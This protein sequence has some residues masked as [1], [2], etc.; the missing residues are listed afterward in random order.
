LKALLD[1]D[2]TRWLTVK[3]K[4]DL[5]AVLSIL[6]RRLFWDYQPTESPQSDKA[7]KSDDAAILVYLWDD[8]V[9]FILQQPKLKA[10]KK[11]AANVIRKALHH[12]WIRKVSLS[13]CDWWTTYKTVIQQNEPQY[14]KEVHPAG[15]RAVHHKRTSTFWE[16]NL[17]SGMFFWQWDEEY[18]K[19][20]ALGSEPR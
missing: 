7:V 10:T 3:E 20:L 15:R 8:G 16:L 5:L 1:G 17:G 11:T 12:C 6:T 19:D 14:W 18:I 9:A 13:W 2:K 4:D